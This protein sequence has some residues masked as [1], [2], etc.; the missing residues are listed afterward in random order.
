MKQAIREEIQAGRLLDL[1]PSGPVLVE[2]RADGRF[3]GPAA[4]EP[5]GGRDDLLGAR[6]NAMLISKDVDPVSL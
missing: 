2:R 6:I 4:V 3:P 5:S 1:D